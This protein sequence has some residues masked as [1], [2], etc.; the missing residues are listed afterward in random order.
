MMDKQFEQVGAAFERLSP[1]EQ[2]MSLVLVTTIIAMI[3]GF[4]GYFVNRGV[5]AREQRIAA[6][7]RKLAQVGELRTD[8]QRRLAEQKQVADR[9]RKNN[10][11]RLLSYLDE[12][13]RAAGID[14]KYIRERPGELT[15]FDQVKE[16]AAEVQLKKI[17]LDRLYEFLRQVESDNPLVKVRRLR[18][19]QR[20]DNRELLDAWVT[21]GTF[22]T[23]S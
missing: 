3:F 16:E 13:G 19:K 7:E 23:S 14:L 17:S 10:G 20:F 22:K 9:V 5:E 1:R 18:I 4:G 21:V 8:Y 11:L 12:K 2:V 15:G 6:K